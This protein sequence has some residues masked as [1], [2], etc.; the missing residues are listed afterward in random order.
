MSDAR[1]SCPICAS[2]REPRRLTSWE[3][4]TWWSC[5]SC[6]GGWREP[7]VAETEDADAEMGDTYARYLDNMRFFEAIAL[8]KTDWILRTVPL[9]DASVLEVGPG[10][11]AVAD[12]LVAGGLSRARYTAVESN[13]TFSDALRKRGFNVFGGDSHERLDSAIAF[14]NRESRFVVVLLDNV[15]EHVP[16]PRAFLSFVRD[17]LTIPFVVLVEVPNERGLRWR[18]P[19]QDALRGVRKPPT[20]PGHI[21]LFTGASLSRLLREIFAGRVAVQGKGLRH[22]DEVR[23]LLQ[24]EEVPP[25]VLAVLAL[26]RIA[27]VDR[28]IGLAYFLRAAAHSGN[29]GATG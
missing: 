1:T 24:S 28:L 29:G 5:R 12:A 10:A 2:T 23:R 19:L 16:D 3:D 14:H 20:F 7:Y 8:E 4:L 18:A 6:G 22:P 26:L 13:P 17:T 11:G 25:A 9:D 21:N 27:P 15:L